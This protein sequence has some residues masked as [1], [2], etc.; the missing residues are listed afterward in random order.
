LPA[1]LGGKIIGRFFFACGYN[2]FSERLFPVHHVQ[3]FA[4]LQVQ[5]AQPVQS[6]SMLDWQSMMQFIGLS[7]SDLD[8]LHAHS[9]FF[10][11]YVNHIVD[12]FYQ[13]VNRLPQL[14]SIIEKHSSID[15]LKQT[16]KKYIL[17][18]SG[19]IIDENYVAERAKVGIVHV[20]VQLSQDWVILSAVIYGQIFRKLCTETNNMPLYE[21]FVKRLAFD[22]T[23]MIDQYMT[24]TITNRAFE[25]YRK[26]MEAWIKEIREYSGQ[27]N[28]ISENLALAATSTTESQNNIAGAMAS[29]TQNIQ[30]IQKVSTFIMDISQ[31][32]N[33]LGL[34][35]S[36][37][38]AHAGEQGRGFN[39]VA[40]E[41]RKLA[42][43][44]QDSVREINQMVHLILEQTLKVD[45]QIH[46]AVANSEEQ[47]AATE[48]LRAII[49]SL[50]DLCNR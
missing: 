20:R 8:F 47:N 36:I 39:I 23:I 26:E 34:N 2:R 29:L 49:Q 21:S 4:M 15:R 11:Q 28:D 19:P 14:C 30:A 13:E 12:T 46:Q 10:E 5:R 25:Q 43:H 31:Q 48:E 22:S 9:E 24:T 1:V 35:A 3:R 18:M 16:A 6:M 32:T 45:S 40:Q 41:I 44:S 38:A 50:N 17:S 7:Q 42:I 33:L 27:I 37:E